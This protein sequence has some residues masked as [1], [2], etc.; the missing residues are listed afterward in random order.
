MDFTGAQTYSSKLLFFG[1]IV[2]FLTKDAQW[3][4]GKCETKREQERGRKQ[5]RER[6]RGHGS[7]EG[8]CRR[9]QLMVAIGNPEMPSVVCVVRLRSSAN[10]SGLQ[11]SS[12]ADLQ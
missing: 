10:V 11:I 4:K 12:A 6:V 3:L 8:N 5:E 7:S 2:Y 9:A 1:Q